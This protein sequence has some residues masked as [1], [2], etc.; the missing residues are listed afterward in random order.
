MNIKRDPSR[1]FFAQKRRGASTRF[2]FFFTMLAAALTALYLANMD[3]V[4]AEAFRALNISGEPTMLP[5]Q[6]ATRGQTLFYDGEL[7]EA[8]AEFEQAVAMRPNNIDYLYELGMMLMEA[9]RF[10]RARE[11][12]AQALE[13]APDDPRGYTLRARSLM[14]SDPPQAI[15]V[16]IQGIDRDPEFAP[17]YAIQ[18]V[19]YTNL[20][21]WQEGLRMAT[22][23]RELDPNDI[24]VQMSYQWPATYRGDFRGA[25]E[26]L[27]TAIGL[28]PNLVTPYFYLARL[29][30][31]AQVGEQTMAI[32]TY[33]RILELSPDNERA[34]LRLCQ[35][36]AA[37]DQARF[38]I[39]QPYC[40]RAIAINPE[41]GDA[42]AQ[43]GQMQYVRRNYEGA[44][45]SFEACIENG[46]QLI[47]C[48]YLMGFSHYRL[49]N[50]A[51]AWEISNEAR[52]I[53]SNM[54]GMGIIVENIDN[55]LDAITRRS[56]DFSDQPIPTT[57]P[58]TPLPP[59]PIGGFGG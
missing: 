5:S 17:L 6:H 36:Y 48:R 18:G 8:I 57:V 27:E 22:R 50:Y 4:Q 13:V 53:A 30:S 59:T 10:D 55:I 25:I 20:A 58:P 7:D 54:S 23:A 16:A 15:Q 1:S 32:A 45:E 12:A 9:D 40:D 34:Y 52:A 51:E 2:L 56:P 24:F 33:Y 39:A 37:V 35:T 49:A 14:W 31:L 41:Y 44:I 26:A 21:R 42:Y 19:A 28:N 3:A 29:Y 43:R 38:D 11:I 47:E 46:S